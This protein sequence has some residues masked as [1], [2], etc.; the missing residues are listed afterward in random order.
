MVSLA[1]DLESQLLEDAED[2]SLDRFSLLEA[3][4]IAGG[5]DSPKQLSHYKHQFQQWVEQAKERCDVKALE[6]EK[7]QE[8]FRFMHEKILWGQYKNNC[9]QLKD[10][11]QNGDY[12]CLSATILFN[13]MA[14]EIGLSLEAVERPG[15]ILSRLQKD[16][17][18]TIETTCPKWFSRQHRQGLPDGSKKEALV[19]AEEE[20]IPITSVQLLSRVYYNRAVELLHRQQFVEAI[21]ATKISLRLDNSH[22]LSK[23]NLLAG[24]NNWALLLCESGDYE[25]AVA[26]LA[27]IRDISPNYGTLT[28]NELHVRQKWVETL[29]DQ[30]QYD[31][32]INVLWQGYFILP[33]AKLFREGRFFLYRRWAAEFHGREL[34]DH[35]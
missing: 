9:S 10:I 33:E 6:R 7:V 20:L 14:A 3:A 8:I 28:E 12:N 24:M 11:F 34:F 17:S 15:H 19:T 4:L 1:G 23:E 30:G 27:S 5:E 13:T 22:D 32:A 18:W 31:R 35:S 29:C 2:N 25:G 26:R 16:P 21:T